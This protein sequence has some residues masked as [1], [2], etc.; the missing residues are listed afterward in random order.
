MQSN[1][2]HTTSFSHGIV[3]L[4]QHSSRIREGPDYGDSEADQH[5][6][7]SFPVAEGSQYKFCVSGQLPIILHYVRSTF[8]TV[9]RSS[10]MAG[11]ADR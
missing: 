8:S 4:Q 1:P 7:S 9:E 11:V 10:V 6:P 2:E 3:A 5:Q